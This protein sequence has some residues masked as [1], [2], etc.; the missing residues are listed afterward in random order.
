M[1]LM[2]FTVCEFLRNYISFSDSH[3]FQK[4]KQIERKSIYSQTTA[5]IEN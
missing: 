1:I 3:F 2:A 5:G 4:E